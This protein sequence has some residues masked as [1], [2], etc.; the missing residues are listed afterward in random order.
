MMLDP[1][2]LTAPMLDHDSTDLETAERVTYLLEQSFCYAYP[3]AIQRLR[4]RLFVLP[5]AQHGDQRLLAHR[6]DVEGAATRQTVRR[7]SRGNTIVRIHAE[8]VD[9]EVRFSVGALLE[10]VRDDVPT[11]LGA[12]AISDRRW[13]LPTRLTAADGRL[14][15]I[16]SQLA[17]HDDT[18]LERAGRLCEYVHSAMT[19][20]HGVTSVR[21][22]A[23]EALAGGRGVCQDAAHVMLA[24]CHLLEVPARY[25]SGHLLGQGG[26]HAWVEVLVPAAAHAVAMPFDPCNGTPATMRYLTVATGRDYNDVPPTS[27]SYLGDPSGTLTAHRRL[28]VVAAA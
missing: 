5:P 22:T 4:H 14:R 17:R 23:A 1:Q 25:V 18:P 3:A 27:G 11:R 28:G 13:R 20:G 7:D 10:R 8:R 15:D 12:A 9:H 2:V 16:A 21:T 6:L 24:L 19:Y 26:T